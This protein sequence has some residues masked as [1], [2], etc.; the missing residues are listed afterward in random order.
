M[1]NR[2]ELK[3]PKNQ[4]AGKQNG[5]LTWCWNYGWPWILSW[6]WNQEAKISQPSE[7]QEARK[8]L[9]PRKEE[10][11]NG[12]TSQ[13]WE[14]Y[15]QGNREQKEHVLL[16]AKKKKKARKYLYPILSSEKG[17]NITIKKLITTG[18]LSCGFGVWFYI[19][20]IV[21]ETPNQ[22]NSK[23]S[24]TGKRLCYLKEENINPTWRNGSLTR[25]SHMKPQ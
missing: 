12:S 2:K 21:P 9:G 7:E 8:A 16:P 5:K 20:C 19:T 1:R 14:G 10:P 18:Q 13:T 15:P 4:V 3:G 11:A 22:Q 6:S 24:Q 25:F 17:Y 23:W